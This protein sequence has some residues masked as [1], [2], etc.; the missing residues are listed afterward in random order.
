MRL[1]ARVDCIS[2]FARSGAVLTL[3]SRWAGV[4]RKPPIAYCRKDSQKA[5]S[6][7]TTGSVLMILPVGISSTE[8]FAH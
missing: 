1:R 2:C 6:Q 5:L 4:W 7:I 3:L 8:K